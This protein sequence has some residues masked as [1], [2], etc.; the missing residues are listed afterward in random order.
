MRSS[1][2]TRPATAS[3]TSP[4]AGRIDGMG[5]VRDGDGV[6]RRAGR[7][8]APGLPNV[9]AF[10]HQ[11]RESRFNT[12]QRPTEH[13]QT[14][15]LS[16]FE[17]AASTFTATTRAMRSPPRWRPL[18]D[19]S[20]ARRSA[21]L[22][23]SCLLRRSWPLLE[24]AILEHRHL[25]HVAGTSAQQSDHLAGANLRRTR[26]LTVRQCRVRRHELRAL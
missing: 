17:R 6:T 26:F 22:R 14:H 5:G 1:C 16:Q 11:C 7:E 24:S 9:F 21:L 13:R 10:N 3:W 20:P 8:A 12:G 18:L 4:R 19:P 23:P 15:S 2:E 25:H